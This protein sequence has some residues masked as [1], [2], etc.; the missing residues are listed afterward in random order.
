MKAVKRYCDLVAELATIGNIKS[1]QITIAGSLTVF[2]AIL[3]S[4]GIALILPLIDYVQNNGDVSALAEESKIWFYLTKIYGFINLPIT[5]L[6]LSVSIFLLISLR[7]AVQYAAVITLASIRLRVEKSLR[8]NLFNALLRANARSVRNVQQG[9]FI[10]LVSLQSTQAAVLVESLGNL[11]GS[12]ITLL[13]YAILTLLAAPIPS[14]LAIS[15]IV[16]GLFA[17]N[18]MVHRMRER[19]NSIV[20]AQKLFT[21]WIGERVNAWRMVKLAV[22]EQREL[23]TC[24]ELT[25]DINK[26]GLSIVQIGAVTQAIMIMS[27]SLL[28]LMGLYISFTY[29][30]I[31]ISVVTLFLVVVMRL[32]PVAMGF[33]RIRQNIENRIASLDRIHEIQD[34]LLAEKERLHGT[35][36]N[37]N[38]TGAIEFQKVSFSYTNGGPDALRNVNLSIPANKMTA[39]LGPSGAGK[40]TLTDLIMGFAEPTS[41]QILFDGR[42]S[43]DISLA[44]LRECVSYLPQ[45]PI[46]FNETVWANISYMRIDATQDE[47]VCAC[48]NANAHEFV[49]AL[50]ET[51]DTLLGEGGNRLS[52]GQKQR[53]SLARALASK[54][55]ILILDEPTS[56]LDAESE[57]L[58][59]NAL[60]MAIKEY[61]K[62]VI[63]IAHSLSLIEH[64]DFAVRIS[65]G[66]IV[67]TGSLE[68]VMS[69][70]S[71]LKK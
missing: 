29:F 15:F 34:D 50:P 19:S 7:Q 24:T 46:V 18:G 54:A 3:E 14:L 20:K 5:L 51:Y 32:M 53:I 36:N 44:S 35:L 17:L 25:E 67:A 45:S 43:T 8:N 16:I 59:K 12:I 31:P 71:S 66:E 6:S 37:V 42:D 40:S 1:L 62:T 23:A 52:G 26:L 60:Q 65:N 47:I 56:A 9:S 49:Q 55:R 2:A 4:I 61:G 64:A 13:A 10:E 39:I 68:T 30:N 57:S 21:A 58:I 63:V 69:D 22:A 70:F 11:W 41:G 28:I 38:L 27:M 48:K 33:T